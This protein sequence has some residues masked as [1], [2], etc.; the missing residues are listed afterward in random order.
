MEVKQVIV[1]RRDLKM[2]RGK[3]I[4][5]GGHA[6]TAWLTNWVLRARELEDFERTFSDTTATG[7]GP[8]PGMTEEQVTWLKGLFTKVC[9]KVNSLD[10]LL[11]IY[12]KS[13]EA[14]LTSH[15]IVDQ[16][17]TE[18]DGVATPTCVGI[19]PHESSK[20]DEITGHL[21]LY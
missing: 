14:K 4:A 1:I 16:G 13:L 5:Q 17:L 15:L 10:E 20:I 7:Y 9:V 3:E 11:E 19:G 2:R 8:M 12:E 18:F 21:K 6:A